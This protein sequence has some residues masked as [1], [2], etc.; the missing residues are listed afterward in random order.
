MSTHHD[1][2][3]GHKTFAVPGGGYRHEPLR[4]SEADAVAA[5]VAQADRKR[6]ELMPTEQAAVDMLWDAHKRLQEFGFKDARYAA[7]DQG[8]E[9]EVIEPGS[10]GI[11]RGHFDGK[12][13]WISGRDGDL[14]PTRPALF[15][16]AKAVQS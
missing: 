5:A 4:R 9:V 7:P 1:P 12:Y 11:H 13:W 2:V 6:A 16:V 15:R 14:Y 8:V 10:T 3:V